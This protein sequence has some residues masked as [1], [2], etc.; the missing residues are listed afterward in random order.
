MRTI[1]RKYP[2]RTIRGDRRRICAYCGGHWYESKMF[3]L[4]NGHWTCTVCHRP[5][6]R[7]EVTL[8]SGHVNV[9][10]RY[11]GGSSDE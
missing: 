8:E 5:G 10:G 6:D 2:H 9:A 7:D 1:P 11:F 4:P 3:E